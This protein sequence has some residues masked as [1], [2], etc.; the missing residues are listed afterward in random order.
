MKPPRIATLTG[1]RDIGILVLIVVTAL[2]VAC[3]DPRFLTMEVWLDILVRSA[4][5]I[6][7]GCGM[8][9]V[10]VIGEIDI[11]VG[12]LTALLAACMGL[13]M[14]SDHFGLP[15]AIGVPAT[16]AIGTGVGLITGSLV[17]F[18]GVPSLVATLG[19]MT[20]LRG[21][22][23]LLMKGQNIGGLPESLQATAKQ[24]WFG[25]P[26]AVWVAGS[27]VLLTAVLIHLM[28]LGRRI[29]AF[30]SS[31]QSAMA[32]GLSESSL[33]LF[34]FAWTGFLTAVAALV[35]IPRLPWIESGIGNDFELLVITCVVVGGVSVSGGRGELLPVILAAVLMTMIRPVLTFLDLGES[36]EKWTRAFHGL[37]ILLAVV[38][39]QMSR[40]S[41]GVRRIS[42]AGSRRV[43]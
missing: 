21:A 37:F 10:L 19:L 24:G 7:V 17:T 18:G 32:A 36:G 31:R 1:R 35:E 16:L 29:Y 2:V 43:G 33:K 30:G 26:L 39:D 40:R 25:V 6:I 8:M 11:S 38:A 13:L 27:I 14:S 34:V 4:P 12:S 9:L 3:F 23:V 20:A 42:A 5:A 15:V 22:T 28:P 41:V